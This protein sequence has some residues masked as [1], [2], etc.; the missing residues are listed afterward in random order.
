[1][2]R[3]IVLVMIL[4][5]GNIARRRCRIE[6]RPA[7]SHA[8]WK[9]IVAPRSGG[10]RRP[11]PSRPY[12]LR[13]RF[14]PAVS[15]VTA[16]EQRQRA[17]SPPRRFHA[18][19]CGIHPAARWH[20]RSCGCRNHTSAPSEIMRSREGVVQP[21]TSTVVGGV[22]MSPHRRCEVRHQAIRP[23]RI[24]FRVNMAR[25]SLGKLPLLEV[26]RVRRR[27]KSADVTPLSE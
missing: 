27:C 17:S 18:P 14:L 1:M 26:R 7:F 3:R 8:R 22:K 13:G 21:S 16:D 19:M 25:S 4:S 24:L 20:R 11:S 12:L 9:I 6:A 10:R 23:P 15:Q 5:F 2:Q